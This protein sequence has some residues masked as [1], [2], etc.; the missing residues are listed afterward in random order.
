MLDEAWPE[1]PG[2][3]PG[4]AHRGAA[5]QHGV[6]W[7]DPLGGHGQPETIQTAEPI[8]AGWGSVSHKG[9]WVSDVA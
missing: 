4:A 8:E 5:A 9:P 1:H 3:S 7:F 2:Q 6:I